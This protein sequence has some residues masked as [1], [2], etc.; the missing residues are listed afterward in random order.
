MTASDSRTTFSTI[1][2]AI[3]DAA[4]PPVRWAA[5]ELTGALRDSGVPVAEDGPAPGALSII[6][7]E[8]AE[9]AAP[10]AFC[11]RRPDGSGGPL[12]VVG[13]DARGR[14]YGLLELAD[15]VRYAADPLGELIATEPLSVSP[16]TPVRSILRVFVSTVQDT[17][18]F[19]D[20]EFW[21]E[22]LTELAT[23]RVNRFQLGFGMQYNY[24]HDIPGDNYLCFPYPYLL[25]VP[26]YDVRASGVSDEERQ[27][28]LETL[29]YISDEAKRRGLHF[30]LGL[31]NHAYDQNPNREDHT[32]TH[33]ITGLTPETHPQYCAAALGRLLRECPAIDG[34]TLRVH[35]EGGVPEPGHEFWRTV[36]SATKDIGRRVEIDMHAKGV[37]E[38]MLQVGRDTGQPIVL[39]AK[40][41]AEHQGL[42][43]QQTTIRDR[44]RATRDPGTGVMAITAHQR[45]FTRYGYGD[46]LRENRDVDLLFRIWPGTQKVLLW[47]D[48]VLA[49]GYGRLGT[50][51]GALGI[52]LCEPLFF[53][54][55][56][57]GG[58]AGGRDPYSDPELQLGGQEWR[59]Y[60]YT[61]RLWGRLLYDP[62]AD[63]E[64]WRRFLRA[65][66]GAAAEAAENAL[67]AA[68]RILPLMTTA[69]GLSGSNNS[70]WPE[71]YLD[72]P[73]AE[74][75]NAQT[76]SRDND[77]PPRF[78]GVSPFDPSLFYRIDD[79]AADLAAGRRDGRYGARQI[80]AWFDGLAD[81]A[82]R[83]L[84]IAKERS[85]DPKEPV[86]R[87]FAV[88][89]AAQAGLGRFFAGKYRAGLAWALHQQTGD[90][91]QLA[92][93][94][95]QLQAA[96]DAWAA[97]VAVT[98]DAYRTDLVFGRRVTERGHWADRLP[99]IDVDLA[100]L[101]RAYDALPDTQATGSAEPSFG[102]RPAVEHVPAATFRRGFAHLVTVVAPALEGS[103]TLHYRHLNQG[104][105]YRTVPM[106]AGGGRF[107]ASIPAGYTDSPYPLAYYFT[108]HAESGDAWIV[109]GLQPS[110]A[111]QPY[112]V[113]RQAP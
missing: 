79:E 112:H 105:D 69:H 12:V 27:R 96:R 91:G 106:S 52:E 67:A 21:S 59:K 13:A 113:I 76:L 71:M 31:W 86:F 9:P 22:Y 75:P 18:W 40:H 94:I 16:A 88:D 80:A 35:Y 66:Y 82:E 77:G 109:P 7:S 70:Y 90:P 111:N 45:R 28:N 24:P 57:D 30:Q 36:L 81:E 98:Q 8:A 33:T 50:I 39:G 68:A 17:P 65:E 60:R 64:T 99:A 108:V 53:A 43:Y 92:E 84:A 104:E 25:E 34:L 107:A 2:L 102:E 61:Y 63:P 11:F 49:A 37:D 51:G 85:D 87:R 15:R 5:D 54:G 93:A 44:E 29:R 46:F 72:M 3:P 14:S 6:L 55:R 83:Q 95:E 48:P 89:V 4:D 100:A 42:P 23:N 41:W 10:E 97:I 103:I 20:R 26:G 62:D 47:G 101:R 110:L 78:T 32:P 19:H 56:M 58:S 38:A 74:G 73:I 1:A